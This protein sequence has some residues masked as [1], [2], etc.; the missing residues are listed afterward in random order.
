MKIRMRI[1]PLPT[2]TAFA[3][4]CLVASAVEARTFTDE[5]AFL[6]AVTG[7]NTESFDRRPRL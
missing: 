4:G 5:A 6:A 3:L 7:P 2:L 1:R